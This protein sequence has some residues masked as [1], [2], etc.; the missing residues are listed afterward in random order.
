MI[1]DI[2]TR[3][4]Q[5]NVEELT[6]AVPGG[7]AQRYLR[8][9]ATAAILGFLFM[10]LIAFR[11]S[12]IDPIRAGALISGVLSLSALATLFGRCSGTARTFLAL[13]LFGVYVALNATTVAMLDV[14]G[15]NGV[16]NLDSMKIQLGIAVFSLS[17][18]YLY[19]RV[20]AQ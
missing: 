15:F 14:V 9:F 10:G 12:L 2:S 4:F 6:G 17:S 5:A 13:Y 19:N 3:D 18:G 8:Q 7:I 16:A 1:S 11:W 20:R